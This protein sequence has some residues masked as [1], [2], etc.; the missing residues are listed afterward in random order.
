[1]VRFGARPQIASLRDPAKADGCC[2]EVTQDLIDYLRLLGGFDKPGR[3]AYISGDEWL[4]GE[5]IRDYDSPDDFGYTDRTRQGQNSH[6]VCFVDIGEETFAID[7]TAAQYG[8][9]AFPLVQRLT[10][11]PSQDEDAWVRR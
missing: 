4:D 7:F 11:G 6:V 5:M 2:Q 8:Y 9:D 3:E 10:R 1:L